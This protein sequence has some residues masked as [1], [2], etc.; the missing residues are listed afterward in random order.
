[1]THGV[2]SVETYNAVYVAAD[3]AGRSEDWP[4]L[5]GLRD[6][7]SETDL[8]VDAYGPA[9]AIAGWYVDREAGR[10]LLNELID[11][12]FH[13]P[14]MFTKEFAT[15]FG[16]EPGWAERERQMRANVPPS[17]IELMEWPDYPPTLEPVLDRV[18]PERE[19]VLRDRL[20]S[21]AGSAWQT[22]VQLL[23]WVTTSWVHGNGH[24][25]RRDALSVLDRVGAGERF[26]CVEYT[27]VL[28]QALNAIGIPA[29]SLNLLMRDHHTGAGRG[30]VVSEAWIDDLG[31]WVL[32]DGQNGAWWG[33]ERNPLG[34]VDLLKRYAAGDR[35]PMNS[36]H[37]SLDDSDQT[38]WFWYFNAATATGLTWSNGPFVPIFQT[39]GVVRSDRLV[40][41]C[42]HVAPDLARIA[43][44]VVQASGPALTFSPVH[45]F[46]TGVLIRPVDTGSDAARLTPGEPF[47]LA[48]PAGT[49]DYEVATT[50]PYGTLAAER[51]RYITR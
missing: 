5:W 7:L 46:A 13:Q 26:A 12:G 43:T 24:V 17:A 50:T 47:E 35:P 9:C 27:I 6:R 15:T 40:H 16:T 19:A 11:N 22:A 33:D 42:E 48:A 10:A 2:D 1:M 32:L 51:L 8:W 41:G 28:S 25:D 37:H 45:P 49:H 3:S 39:H 4:T 44:G 21:A 14:E 29:R 34:V 18:A 30:H 36:S 20:P 38:V 31:R 23:N